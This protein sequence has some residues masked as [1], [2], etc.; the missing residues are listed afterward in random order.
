MISKNELKYFSSLLIK[1]FR[2]QEEKFIV[3]GFKIVEEGLNSNYKCD[4][5]FFT[6]AFGDS[7]PDLLAILKKKV[8]RILE[9]KSL[10]FQKISDTKSPQ[11]IAA[12]FNKNYPKKN[13]NIL[14]D[15]LVVLIDNI[16]D[17]GNLGTIIRTC[18]WFGIYN[19]LITNQ[20]V[21]YLN[22][23]VIRATMGSL[24]H[25]NIYD[26]IF[27]ND[28][29]ELRSNGYQIVCADVKGKNIFSFKTNKK[30]IT[31]FSNESIGPSEMIK[32]LA[33]DFITIPGKGRAESL[34]VSSAASI[35][36]SRLVNES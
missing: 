14:T 19:I 21:E 4:A 17:P 22:P 25:L 29:I 20:S 15:K 32:G 10:E 8:N 27:E 7:F 23:K 11:G 26:E 3:E 36:I 16:S 18:D 13:L 9:L 1:K 2:Q 34:N 5:V 35:I 6:P 33:D 30:T 28:L 12:V 31:A 24:F